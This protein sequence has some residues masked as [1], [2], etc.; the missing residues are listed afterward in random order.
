MFRKGTVL[1]TAAT[2]SV[3]VDFLLLPGRP[4]Q[5]LQAADVHSPSG[6]PP[7]VSCIMASRGRI[8][9]A[10]HA[11][12]CYRRQ[13]HRRRELVIATAAT[14]DALASYVRQLGDA[15]IRLIVVAGLETPGRLRNAAIAASLGEIVAI[16][17]DDDLSSPDRIA[18]QYAA[19]GSAGA[20]GCFLARVLLWWP[21]RRKLSASSA[22]IWENTMLVRRADLPAYREDGAPGE[23]TDVAQALRAETPLVL[24][25]RPDAYVYVSHGGNLCSAA[26][27]EML[28]DRASR[29]FSGPDY[30]LALQELAAIMPVTDYA[31]GVAT[32]APA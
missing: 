23:D 14:D 3:R 15:S 19:M 10:M 22:R 9:P 25:D 17:D 24:V 26:H 2:G 20:A 18:M 5:T 6:S 7:L 27:F 28:F 8:F 12:D 16:W 11:I 13:S 29:L 32:I 21:A 31:E 30:D 1:K 4:A